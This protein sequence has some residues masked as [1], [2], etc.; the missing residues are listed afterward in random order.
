MSDVTLTSAV[1]NNLL[2]LQ[3]TQKLVDRTQGRLSTGLKVASAI[4]DPVAFFQAKA[5]SD[6]AADFQSK[7]EAVDQGVSTL[8]TALQGITGVTTLVKQ[9]KGLALNAQSASSQQIGSLVQQYNNLRTQLNNL[10]Q[11]SQYQGLNLIAGAGETL[12]V[13]FSNITGSSLAVSSV[14]VTT[15]SKGL[16][17][18]KAV[19][20]NG[21]F[22]VSFQNSTGVTVGA[23]TVEVTY[24]GTATTLTSG[25]YT[26][27]YGTAT[28]SLTVYSAGNITGAAVAGTA[29][30]LD[31]NF[32]TTTST[33]ADGTTF[34]LRTNAQASY[35]GYA[36][37]GGEIQNSQ[38]LS[39]ES[40]RLLVSGMY[41]N[42]A[43][44]GFFINGL[45]GTTLNSGTYTFNI[46]TQSVTFLVSCAGSTT[47]TFSTT[48][49]FSNGQNLAFVQGCSTSSSAANVI[50]LGGGLLSATYLNSGA[51]SSGAYYSTNS[52]LTTIYGA[53]VA[54]TGQYN[55]VS[56]QEVL[57]ANL[58]GTINKLV[59][60]LDSNLQTL[61]S[62]A[63]SLGTNVALLNTRLDFTKNYVDVLQGGAGKLTLADLNEEGAN[64]L[65]LQTR[66]QLGIQALSF[67]GQNEKSILSLFR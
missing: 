18:S 22:Q 10:A 67:A 30:N 13:S 49:V 33:F 23:D 57:D 6:R 46:A 34:A 55:N 31:Q 20:S 21:G 27:S 60:Q 1:R 28:V 45:T 16:N 24:S 61:R 26:F 59:T 25:A 35:G 2:A 12:S 48:S 65:A 66:Q 36:V 14:D 47:G 63:Q 43:V 32:L 17:L 3:G 15:S 56:G 52:S 53:N 29:Y 42:A 58:S 40:Q 51:I 38:H 39:I 37:T 5:L 44:S 19:T 41:V 54:A 7:K 8:T 4:D 50:T 11:D 62:Y 64:L 9:V